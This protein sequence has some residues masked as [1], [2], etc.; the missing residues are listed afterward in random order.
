MTYVKKV[1]M[2]TVAN[3]LELEKYVNQFLLGESAQGFHIIDIYS[4]SN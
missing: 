4:I 2:F 1:R 3:S